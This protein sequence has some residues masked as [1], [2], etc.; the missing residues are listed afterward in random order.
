MHL[1]SIRAATPGGSGAPIRSQQEVDALLNA[2]I[3]AKQD[4]MC[5]NDDIVAASMLMCR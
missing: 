2:D 3:I 1:H 4:A 5:C